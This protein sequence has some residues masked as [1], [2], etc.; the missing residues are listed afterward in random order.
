MREPED[1]EL[2]ERERQVLALVAR[3]MTNREI[4]EHLFTSTSTVKICLHQA[5]VKL[6]ARN[7]AQAVITALQRGYLT[8][9]DS[10]SLEELADLLAS[11]GPESI[12]KVAQLLRQKLQQHQSQSDSK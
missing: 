4:A 3:G 6:G 12:E 1:S 5:C 11:W 10:F 9:Q 7:R 2:N 8:T